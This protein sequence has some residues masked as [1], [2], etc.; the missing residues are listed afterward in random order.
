MASI[1]KQ[2]REVQELHRKQLMALLKQPGNAECVDCSGKHPTWASTNIGCFI[3]IRCSGL[4]RQLGVHVSKVKSCTMDLWEAE[5]IEFMAKMGNYRV[6][7]IYE[8]RVPPKY[9]R[10]TQY[11]SSAALLQWIQQKYVEKAFCGAPAAAAPQPTV[12]A[13]AAPQVKSMNSAPAPMEVTVRN[14]ARRRSSVSNTAASPLRMAGG[15]AAAQLSELPSSPTEAPCNRTAMIMEWMRSTTTPPNEKQEDVRKPSGATNQDPQRPSSSAAPSN[16]FTCSSTPLNMVL[17]STEEVLAMQR[18]VCS[19]IKL[20]IEPPRIIQEAS[21][22]VKERATDEVVEKA[23]SPFSSHSQ[24]L[25]VSPKPR[26]YNPLASAAPALVST[27]TKVQIAQQINRNYAPSASPPFGDSQLME[28]CNKNATA[29]PEAD[30]PEEAVELSAPEDKMLT[31]SPDASMEYSAVPLM[32]STRTRRS[33][34]RR[35]PTRPCYTRPSGSLTHS[36]TRSASQ[37]GGVTAQPLRPSRVL[38]SP[39]PF[40]ETKLTPPRSPNEV[41]RMQRPS[42]FRCG[43]LISPPADQ[44]GDEQYSVL[45]LSASINDMIT[46]QA[47]VDQQLRRLQQD[48]KTSAGAKVQR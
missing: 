12:A 29:R 34:T 4:H 3:C 8:A 17:R 42:W 46:M 5:Q 35:A 20:P 10:P 48:S 26:H 30:E 7:A 27:S 2:S 15:K 23:H 41:R 24:P 37:H 45:E 43:S 28:Q 13:V 38:F 14:L 6:R 25:L 39:N 32:A 16:G 31:L 36:S 1:E 21:A 11:D 19:E 9:I 40:Q 22:M 18:L 33:A 47:Q 44:E